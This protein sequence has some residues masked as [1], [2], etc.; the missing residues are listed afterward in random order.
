M[1]ARSTAKYGKW[2]QDVSR[3]APTL[4]G[5]PE[6]MLWTL[7]NRACEALRK[8]GVITD[9]EAIRI[10]S[11]IEYEFNRFFGKPD[12]SHAARSVAIDRALKHWLETYPNGTIVSLG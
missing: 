2:I 7:H 5:V 3:V 1:V 12:G 6:T 4:G 8:D 11:G 10:Y 9:P